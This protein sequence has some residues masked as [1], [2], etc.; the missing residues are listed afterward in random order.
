MPL[1]NLILVLLIGLVLGVVASVI[2]K[3]RGL[4]FIINIVLGT[5]GGCIGAFAPAMFGDSL[6]INVNAPGYLLR[7]ILG[8]FLMLLVAGLFRPVKP[9]SVQ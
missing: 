6:A 8:A 1:P 2:L 7:A 5:L 4:T 3:C 9:R